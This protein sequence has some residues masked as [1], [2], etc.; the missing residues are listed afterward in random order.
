VVF[1]KRDHPLIQNVVAYWQG[2]HHEQYATS[3]RQ[4][5]SD[6]YG[7]HVVARV[8]QSGSPRGLAPEKRILDDLRSDAALTVSLLG[9]APEDHVLLMRL[10][11]KYGRAAA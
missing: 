2:R 8:A 1:L 7:M 9:L 3:I 11:G 5:V 10:G 4:D 6:V